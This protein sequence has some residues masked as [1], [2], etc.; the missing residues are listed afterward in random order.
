MGWSAPAAQIFLGVVANVA[1]LIVITVVALGLIHAVGTRRKRRLRAFFGSRRD[2][3][4]R[5]EVVVSNI[6]VR[7]GGTVGLHTGSYYGTT[8]TEGEYRAATRLRTVFQPRTSITSK[9]FTALAGQLGLQGPDV[10]LRSDISVSPPYTKVNHPDADLELHTDAAIREIAQVALAQP[11]TYVLIGGPVYNPLTAY[12][13]QRQAGIRGTIQ[14]VPRRA[15]DGTPTWCA[16]VCGEEDRPF[17]RRE[18]QAADG[19]PFYT[20]LFYIQKIKN[21]GNC[22]AVFLCVGSTIAATS[23]AVEMLTSWP[24]LFGKFGLDDFSVLFQLETSDR[25]A[26]ADPDHR[27]AR[28]NVRQLWPPDVM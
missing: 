10:V 22:P 25:A 2:G 6:Q 3:S 7:P 28:F 12:V 13:V 16:V 24:R 4:A 17:E 5:I 9:L 27:P 8:I 1:S 20:E 14:M 19:T 11:C 21:F 26:F 15:S 18:D 23:A